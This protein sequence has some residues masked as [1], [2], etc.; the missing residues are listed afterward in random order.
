MKKNEINNLY[1]IA[2]QAKLRGTN[3][4]VHTHFHAG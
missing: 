3:R 4:G 1:K 2:T